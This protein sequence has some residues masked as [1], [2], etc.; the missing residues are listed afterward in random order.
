MYQS[1]LVILLKSLTKVEINHFN[2]FVDA[3]FFNKNPKINKLLQLLIPYYPKFLSPQVNRK[4]IYH[5]IFNDSPIKEQKLR[6]LSTD[7][8]NLL[9]QFLVLKELE[10]RP[11]DKCTYLLDALGARDIR[12]FDKQVLQKEKILLDQSPYQ[13]SIFYQQAYRYQ[14]ALYNHNPDKRALSVEDNISAII[15]NLDIS[16][17]IKKLQ[18]SAELIN[19]TNLMAG[20]FEPLL[21]NEILA[22]L[23]KHEHDNVPEISIYNQILKTLLFSEN[24][25]YYKQLKEKLNLQ[26]GQL[27]PPV[28]NDMYVY[29]RNYCIKKINLGQTIYLKELFELYQTLIDRRIIFKND[30][31]SQWDYKNIVAVGLRLK[32]FDWV[33]D[34]IKSYKQKLPREAVENAYNYNL[35][36]YHFHTG[37]YKKTLDLLNNVLFTDVYYHLDSKSLLMKTYYAMEESDPLYSLI[38]AFYVYLRRNRSISKYQLKSYSNFLHYA[39]RLLKYRYRRKEFLEKLKP[40]IENKEAVANKTWLLARIDE[41]I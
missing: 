29:A 10:K 2:D 23:D 18:Y 11:F 41:L 31:L 19:H 28:I 9:E 3:S 14:L 15:R 17:I 13:N 12:Q 35:A 5:Q 26:T 32:A 8:T 6:Y 33:Y 30:I 27:P 24:E 40:E 25:T 36:L 38:E 37:Q 4:N 16:Y 7:L 1:K 21:L 22:Y 34:F 20:E 39:K